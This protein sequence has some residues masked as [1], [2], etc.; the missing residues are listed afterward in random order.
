MY[1][2]M[3]NN[4]CIYN[5]CIHTYN[6]HTYI[7]AYIHTHTHTYVC[8]CVYIYVYIYIIGEGPCNP[9]SFHAK[10]LDFNADDTTPWPFDNK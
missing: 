1:V 8:V 9:R 5:M 2:C 10:T 7:H 6:I 4:V 3:Y